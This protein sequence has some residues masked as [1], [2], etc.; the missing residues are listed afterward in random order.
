MNPPRM[1]EEV[2]SL[3]DRIRL[4]PDASM[5]D[6]TRGVRGAR[7]V[8]VKKNGERL[9]ETVLAPRGDPENPLT[10]DDIIEKL[11]ACAQGQADSKKLD[12]LVE[13]ILGIQGGRS[14][15]NPMTVL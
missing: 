5:E 7:V 1:T 3:I 12:M 8:I 4:I 11:R 15:V 13:K 2:V 10:R 6:R 9:E 14:F